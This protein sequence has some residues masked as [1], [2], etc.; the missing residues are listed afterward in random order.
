MNKIKFSKKSF[1]YVIII[2]LILYILFFDSASF[3]KTLNIKNKFTLI[4]RIIT[5]DIKEAEKFY[6][7]CLNSGQEGVIIKNLDSIYKPGKRVGYWYKVKPIMETLDLVITKAC[8]G[9]GKRANW[10]SSLTL[11]AR[12]YETGEFL[13]TGKIGTGLNENQLKDVTKKLKNLI[14]EQS[15][16]TLKVIPK[17]VVEIGYEEIQRSP[18]YQTGFALRFPRLIRF[19]EDRRPEGI[20]TPKRIEKLFKMQRKAR[21]VINMNKM[22]N[23]Q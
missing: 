19:R 14:I 5:K 13:E 2:L 4:D 11:S 16:K 23:N 8:W 6:H 7:M 1:V 12:N 15:G 20:D 3:Y 21:T 9:E 22:S 10:L 18:K 17:I